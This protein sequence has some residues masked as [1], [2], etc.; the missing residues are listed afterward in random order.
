MILEADSHTRYEREVNHLQLM[1]LP[2]GDKN[3]GRKF[4][5]EF[6]KCVE[7][8]MRRAMLHFLGEQRPQTLR[9]PF[10]AVN[11]D[12][13]TCMRRTSQMVGGIML[14]EVEF[15]S[16]FLGCL[17][18][19]VN[20][21]GEHTAKNP[22]PLE[23]PAARAVGL[24]RG[25]R[26]LFLNARGG[27]PRAARRRVARLDPRRLRRCAPARARC[28]RHPQGHRPYPAVVPHHRGEALVAAGGLPLRQALRGG[29]RHRRSDEAR[30]LRANVH[31]HNPLLLERA[32]GLHQLLRQLDYLPYKQGEEVGGGDRGRRP[33]RLGSPAQDDEGLP[34]HGRAGWADR[35][36]RARIEAVGI[37]PAGQLSP[38]GENRGEQAHARHDRTAPRAAR[39]RRHAHGGRLPQP[40][41]TRLRALARRAGTVLS[42]TSSGR[43]RRIPNSPFASS[44]SASSPGSSSSRRTCRRASSPTRPRRT[45][46][47]RARSTSSGLRGPPCTTTQQRRPRCAGSLTGFARRAGSICLPTMSSGCSTARCARASSRA[48]HSSR[49]AASSGSRPTARAAGLS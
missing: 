18:C 13:L 32:E 15:R 7:Q 30:A 3:H 35:L 9:R 42:S 37:R 6:T 5:K 17:T 48:L 28:Q 41:A 23:G 4:V 27:A 34:I 47:W 46:I 12:K 19:G 25:G 14:V 49:A 36:A 26:R 31:L 10:F 11:A 45:R 38:L 33:R 1:G 39:R 2:V 44:S 16:I 29:P 40:A 24:I 8:I 22:L 20:L 43:T 21:D